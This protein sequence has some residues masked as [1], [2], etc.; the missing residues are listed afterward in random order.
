MVNTP[1]DFVHRLAEIRMPLVFNPYR[2]VCPIHDLPDAP[3]I[4]QRNLV[5]WIDAAMAQRADT[6]WVARDLGYRGGRRTGLPLT[7][8]AHLTDAADLMGGITLSRA[9]K[10]AAVAERTAAVIWKMLAGIGQPQVLWNIFPFH[11]HDPGGILSNRC[12]TKKER[13]IT[14]PFLTALLAMIKPRR[15]IAIGRDSADGLRDITL[16]IE[17]VRHPSY[18]GQTEFIDGINRIYGVKKRAI[19]ESESLRQDSLPLANSVPRQW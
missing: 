6:V 16:P 12:H 8:E 1:Q 10:G 14:W 5:Q 13:E 7:D 19:P 9:T 11:P 3:V 18:G 17:Y 2:D 4:R 15:I